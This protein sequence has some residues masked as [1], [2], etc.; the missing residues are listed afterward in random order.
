MVFGK[1]IDNGTY[2]DLHRLQINALLSVID[3]ITGVH[4]GVLSQP[5]SIAPC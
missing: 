3:S 2:S 5:S 1:P 4:K